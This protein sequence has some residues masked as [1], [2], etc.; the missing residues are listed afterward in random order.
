MPRKGYKP[1]LSEEAVRIAQEQAEA[2]GY[3]DKAVFRHADLNYEEIPTADI[4]CGLGLLDWITLEEVEK[5]AAR[6][7]GPYVLFSF[8]EQDNSI[9]E[10]VH[11]IYLVWRLKI[12][13]IGVQAYHFK[14]KDVMRIFGDAG[15]KDA[16]VL[17]NKEMR[18]GVIMHSLP[19]E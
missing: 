6:I 8:S 5:L 16:Q 1:T 3:K 13:G 14:R 15:W 4:T 11:R 10:I 17:K 12:Q 7:T 19:Q 9:A 2:A 18:F